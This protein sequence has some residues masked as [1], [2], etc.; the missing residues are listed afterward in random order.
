[1]EAHSQKEETLKQTK[2]FLIK[3]DIS[4][5]LSWAIFWIIISYK[6]LLDSQK[7]FW[8]MRITVFLLYWGM[9]TARNLQLSEA[10]G[11]ESRE[12][13]P[14]GFPVATAMNKSSFC[15]YF[16]KNSGFIYN[17]NCDNRKMLFWHLILMLKKLYC[18]KILQQCSLS[19]ILWILH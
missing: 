18:A 6:M 4:W 7:N 11:A 14:P 8:E 3:I 10:R 1:M 19:W 5:L 16:Y 13:A 17:K 9:E 2:V 12:H 15:L